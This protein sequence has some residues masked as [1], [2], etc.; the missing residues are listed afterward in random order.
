MQSDPGNAP[1]QGLA[2]P[3]DLI[4]DATAATFMEDVIDASQEA[5]I[6]V[7]FWAP[8]C[9]PCKQFTPV[10]EKVVKSYGGKVKL[11]KVN[12]DEQQGLAAQLRI[13]SLPTVYIFQNGR[14]VDGFSGAQPESVVRKALERFLGEDDQDDRT[15][16]L[17]AAEEAL[18]NGDLQSAA[19]IYAAILG[20]DKEDVEALAG[21]AQCY[22]KSGDTERAEQTIELVPPNKRQSA[23]VERVTAALALARKTSNSGSRAKFEEKIKLNPSDHQA[24]FDLALALVA[25]ND[26]LGAVDHLIEIVRRDRAW[27]DEAARKQLLEL[28]DAWGPKNSA[29]IEGRKKLSAILFA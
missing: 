10:L 9:G 8:W 5:L 14:P 18:S 13:Q 26:N 3:S 16:L 20:N 12:A 25:E 19:E 6:V 24:R 7:D 28:F 15:K 27:N 23:A 1:T 4:K 22:L 2:S 21:L 17:A 11:A 29:T